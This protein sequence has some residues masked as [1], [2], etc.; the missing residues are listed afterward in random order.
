MKLTSV[1]IIAACLQVSA[2]GFSQKVSLNANN[3]PLQK[4]FEEI[5]KQTDNVDVMYAV[6][7]VD[8]NERLIGMLSFFTLSDTF[9]AD[10]NASSA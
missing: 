1:L 4:V 7:V 5:R 3:L 8:N 6:Y 9:L 2:K 10:F